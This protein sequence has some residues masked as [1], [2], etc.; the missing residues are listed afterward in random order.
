[1]WRAQVYLLGNDVKYVRKWCKMFGNEFNID[2]IM[3][4]SWCISGGIMCTVNVNSWETPNRRKHLE[5]NFD[6]TNVKFICNI[7][8]KQVLTST[9]F[10]LFMSTYLLAVST[11]YTFLIWHISP[12][13]RSDSVVYKMFYDAAI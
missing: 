4:Q 11:I 10:I 8:K 5:L 12:G 6:I 1:M 9:W 7:F 2:A 13:A 3:M